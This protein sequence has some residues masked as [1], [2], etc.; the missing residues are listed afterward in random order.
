VKPLKPIR[1]FLDALV[2]PSARHDPVTAERHVAF[3]AP[4]LC[5]SLLALGAFPVFLAVHGVPST[6][7][8][9]VLAWMIFPIATACFL[10]RTGRY[11]A[12]H[13]LSAF[14]LTCIVTIVAA[15]SGGTNSFAAVWLV[16][17]PLEAALSGSRRAVVVA[18]LLAIGGVGLLAVAEALF[19]LRLGAPHSSGLLMTLGVVSALIYATGIALGADGVAIW[20][21]IRLGHDA[22]QHRLPAFSATDVITHHSHGGR[23]VYASA[24]THTVLGIPASDLRGYGLFDRIHIADRPAWLRALSDAAATGD[25]CEIEFRL[26][27]PGDVGIV[28]LEMRCRPFEGDPGRPGDGARPEVIAVMREVT[29]RKMR[30]DALIAARAEAE[31]ANAAKSRFLAS[32]GH[33]LRTPLNAIIGFSDLLR[34]DTLSPVET[35]RRQEYAR[36]ISQSGHHLLAVV[37]EILDMSRLETGNFELSLESVRLDGVIANCLDLLTLRADADGITFNIEVP[38]DLPEIIAD[39][40]AVLQI[41]INLVAN[42]IKFSER[43]G[44]VIIRANVDSEQAA[45]EVADTGIGIA[46]EDLTRIGH[47]FF[48]GCHAGAGRGGSGLGLSIVKGLVDLHGGVL[49]VQSKRGSG[50]RMVVRLPVACTATNGHEGAIPITRGMREHVPKQQV[51]GSVRPPHPADQQAHAPADG[52]AWPDGVIQVQ[53]RA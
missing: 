16:L 23:I 31:R 38:A 37:N 47:P 27:R 41:L 1:D 48:R 46:P 24:N 40:R 15:S 30:Q 32:I 12:A 17:I 28:W 5:G 43:G 52:E 21:L 50:T 14:A 33:E 2:H 10:S 18:A 42:A 9:L 4:R 3:M 26:R 51:G 22:Q 25:T 6:V 45:I 39:R 19:G 13:A 34:D 7:E 8:F 49:E 36:I 35:T 11:D 20:K 53:K 44:T 29:E